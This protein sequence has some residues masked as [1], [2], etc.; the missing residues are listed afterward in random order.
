MLVVLSTSIMNISDILIY[1]Q[2]SGVNL[3]GGDELV[4]CYSR[5]IL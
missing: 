2:N 3:G 4:N 5:L 1:K